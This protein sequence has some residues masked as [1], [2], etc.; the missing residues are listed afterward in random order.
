MM[1]M[2]R[3]FALIAAVGFGLGLHGK[4]AAQPPPTGKGQRAQDFIAAFNKGDAKAVAAF[5]TEGATYV[6]QAG[7]EYKGRA[8]IE[9]LYAKV[10]AEGK[11]AKL[12]IHVIS[13][14]Q[15]TPDVG[16]EEGI[17][18]VTPADGGPPSV[19][20]FSAVFVK[21]DSVWY[22]ENVHDSVAHPPSNSE[23]FEDLQGLI[24]T[25]IGEEKGESSRASYSWAENRNFIVCSFATTLNG[26]PVIGGTQ[27]IGWDAVDKQ[28]RSWAFYSG[29]GSSEG[30]WS[31]EGNTWSAKISAKTSDG[32]KITATNLL[33]LTDADHVTTQLTKLTVDGQ[34]VPDPKPTKLKRVR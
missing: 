15:L 5:W 18:E 29:G 9:K 21:K 14:K 27:W 16:I 31:K 13:V 24:G 25:W 20:R 32:K 11:G 3:L 8:A 28:V 34:S 2:W 23:H 4:A 26:V 17:T 22:L 33:T 19:A 6:D 1:K 7:R 10:F 12:S 30:V